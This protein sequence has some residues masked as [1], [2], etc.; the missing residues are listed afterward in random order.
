MKRKIIK[1]DREKCNGCGICVN[2]CAEGAIRIVDGKAELV[3]E[4]YCDGLGACI[5]ECPQDAIRMEERE[6]GAFDEKSVQK[7]LK[8][9]SGKNS[10]ANTGDKG[11]HACPGSLPFAFDKKNPGHQAP[12]AS[13]QASELTQW[14]VQLHLVSPNAA[15]WNDADLLI[16]A[17]CV[18]FTYGAFHADLLK[19]RK[20]AIA[21]P[22]LDDT[23]P[24][25][26][27][28]KTLFSENK[29]RS[30]TVA[31]MEVPCCGGI[32]A[33]TKKAIEE[34]GKDIPFKTVTVGIKGNIVNN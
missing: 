4:T 3:S 7:H 26:E 5:G 2:A 8:E 24:Y 32:E 10:S 31:R 6:A 34:S 19:G 33:I 17:D 12:A 11:H 25:L 20:L 1:I 22:K 27:K 15:Y 14:P 18:P 16:C 30:I 9:I 28:L 13:S 23:G 21:C 29:I